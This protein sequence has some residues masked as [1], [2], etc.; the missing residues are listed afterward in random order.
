MRNTLTVSKI[1][2]LS[3]L[4]FLTQF[5]TLPYFSWYN[6]VKYITIVIVGVYVVSRYKCFIKRKYIT[7]NCLS[8]FFSGMLL[9]TSFQN[10][11]QITTRNPFLAAIVFVALFLTF[12][13]FM[14]IMV[15]KNMVQRVLDTF[16]KTTL[17][18]LM[19]NDLLILLYPDLY[20]TYGENYFIGTKF[21]VVYL[22][23]LLVCLYIGKYKENNT[24]SYNNI[25]VFGIL[26]WTFG[27]GT[28]VKC[29]T[30]LVG[31]VI[32]IVLMLVISSREK[33]FLNP[34]FYAAVQA[35]CFGFVF[36]CEMVLN[37]P[38]VENFVVNILGKNATMSGRANIYIKVPMLLTSHNAWMTGFGYATS[39]ELGRKLGGFP[40]TQNG[41]L[42]WIWN[43][44]I[45][46]TIVMITIFMTILFISKRRMTVRNRGR[47]LPL[48]TM[49]YLLTIL[50][51]VEIT[52]TQLYFALGVCVMG[53]GL[54][55]SDELGAVRPLL[56]DI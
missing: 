4:I 41:V 26:M 33:L 24:K 53:V 29:S 31:T 47:L 22:H 21:E 14:E 27:I 34:V 13:L 49:L 23:F 11:N 32:L 43:A 25:V 10:R 40:D 51:T 39:Y 1:T 6:L 42:E 45:P 37:N 38:T 54:S 19:I 9:W 8:L 20:L 50:G 56:S 2:L 52:I 5:I 28:L 7:I 17:V 46:T 48:I 12:L 16:Y 18:I 3:I 55:F 35:L 36:F 30:G 15:E 44:G